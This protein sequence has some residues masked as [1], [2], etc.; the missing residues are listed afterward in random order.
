MEANSRGRLPLCVTRILDGTSRCLTQWWR[1]GEKLIGKICTR[2]YTVPMYFYLSSV[3][4]SLS[5]SS[6]FAFIYSVSVCGSLYES[7]AS[8]L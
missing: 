7:Y 6:K 3:R 8:H 5:F 2:R 4:L 1:E